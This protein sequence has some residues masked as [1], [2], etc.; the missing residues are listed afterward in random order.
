MHDSETPDSPSNSSTALVWGGLAFA[1]LAAFGYLMFTDRASEQP[2]PAIGKSLSTLQLEP[3]TGGGN[4]I[5]AADL[6]GK[7]TLI[8][9]WGTW[10]PPCRL[11]FPGLA[12]ITARLKTE[13]DFLYLSVS[14][15][16]EG[17]EDPVELESST[18]AFLEQQRVSHPTYWDPDERTR[19]ALAQLGT[20]EGYPTTVLLDR[21]GVIRAV[22][23][24][25]RRGMEHEIEQAAVELLRQASEPKQ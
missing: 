14:C 21:Q 25:Y 2:S 3:L 23:S 4:P 22:W 8:N 11:E 13:P 6:A 10:C 15:G 24:G 19:R 16:G 7:V 18:A 9:F 20:M 12:A 17:N 5:S 1:A